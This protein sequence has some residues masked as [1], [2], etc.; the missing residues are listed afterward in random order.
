MA[1]FL[2]LPFVSTDGLFCLFCALCCVG[3]EDWAG[4]EDS[5]VQEIGTTSKRKPGILFYGEDGAKAEGRNTTT[6]SS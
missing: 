3:E 1:K 2:L 4:E 6:G 5:G